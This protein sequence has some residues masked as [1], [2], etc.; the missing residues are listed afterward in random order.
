MRWRYLIFAHPVHLILFIFLFMLQPVWGQNTFRLASVPNI[1]GLTRALAESNLNQAG[2]SVKRVIEK[3]SRIPK[4]EVIAQIPI[5]GKILRTGSGVTLV[6]SK[7]PSQPEIE[8]RQLHIQTDP[9]LMTGCRSGP[10]HITTARLIITGKRSGPMHIHIDPLIMTGLRFGPL[11][12]HTEKLMMTGIRY[13]PLHIHTDRL[14][15]TGKRFGP[16]NIHTSRLIMTGK[17]E[18]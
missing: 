8:G 6:I 5:A 12:L 4:G 10:L 9:L 7:G 1:V 16:L 3:N 18:E 2:F 15:M 17:R 13:G 14:T 11:S